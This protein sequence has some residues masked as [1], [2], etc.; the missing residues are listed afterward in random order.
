MTG[1]IDR[2]TAPKLPRRPTERGRDGSGE[3]AAT[4]QT[5]ICGHFGRIDVRPVCV[6]TTR[7]S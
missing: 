6:S 1:P 2:T 3:P 4:L 7:R 5:R